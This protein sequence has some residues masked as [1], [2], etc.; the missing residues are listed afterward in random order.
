MD[1]KT[2]ALLQA[3]ACDGDLASAYPQYRAA[4]LNILTATPCVDNNTLKL[5][6]T[7]SPSQ[8]PN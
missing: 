6:Y 3:I 7:Q 4:A 1:T 2:L 8:F 5:M